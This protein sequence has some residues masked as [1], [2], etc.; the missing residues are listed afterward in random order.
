MHHADGCG[1]TEFDGKIAIADGIDDVLLESERRGALVR[2]DPAVMP[3]AYHCAVISAGELGQLRSIADIIRLGRVVRLTSNEIVL[4]QGSVAASANPLYVDCSSPGIP[5]RPSM[6][7][8]EDGR[9]T[10]QWV[11]TCQPT[12]SAAFIAHVEATYDDEALKNE[13]CAPIEPPEVPLDYLRML[14]RELATRSRLDQ[15]PEIRTWMESCRLDPFSSVAKTQIGVNAEAT[16]HL[17]RY[18]TNYTA[19]VD[20][21]DALLGPL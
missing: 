2:L 12:F 1:G 3:E 10:P 9:I 8:F 11:R 14:Q 20:R 13:L 4:E 19:A 21:L 6:P 15:Q 18:L 16:E 5:R 7:V 17:G